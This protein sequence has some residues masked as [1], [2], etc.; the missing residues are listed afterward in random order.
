MIIMLCDKKIAH[1]HHFSTVTLHILLECEET[2]GKTISRN[3]ITEKWEFK[4]MAGTWK[5]E[6]SQ[7]GNQRAETQRLRNKYPLGIPFRSLTC[8]DTKLYKLNSYLY[9]DQIYCQEFTFR[10]STYIWN[11]QIC[12]LLLV[13]TG[14]P[15][16]EAR[17]CLTCKYFTGSVRVFYCVLLC[18][19]FYVCVTYCFNVPVSHNFVWDSVIKGLHIP[20]M[21][22][23][24]VSMLSYFTCK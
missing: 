6:P 12:E 9:F 1:I 22:N 13:A 18:K 8:S 10:K 17:V 19:Y 16:W 3:K 4:N 2:K 15:V 21:P 11:M 24:Q 14:T 7:S 20:T 5:T 23:V